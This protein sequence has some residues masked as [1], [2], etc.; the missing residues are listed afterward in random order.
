MDC[1]V[2]GVAKSWTGLSYFHFHF[3]VLFTSV[4][5]LLKMTPPRT[6]DEV[7]FGKLSMET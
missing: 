1:I 7:K 5:R 2:H 4:L 3:H 6:K